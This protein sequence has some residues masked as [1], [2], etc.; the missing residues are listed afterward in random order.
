MS[1]LSFGGKDK[2]G[3]KRGMGL[4]RDPRKPMFE[5]CYEVGGRMFWKGAAEGTWRE[6]KS[7]AAVVG[8]DNLKSANLP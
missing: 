2:F 1:L 5:V 3:G 8:I 6:H 4:P 7:M